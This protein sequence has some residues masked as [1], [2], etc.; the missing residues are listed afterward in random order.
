MTENNKKKQIFDLPPPDVVYLDPMFPP[1]T[2]PSAVKKNI[3]IL[4]SLLDTQQKIETDNDNID[5]RT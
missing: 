5:G 2:R 4:H 3:Q 1:R